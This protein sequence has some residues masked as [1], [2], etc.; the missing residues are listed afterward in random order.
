MTAAE[1]AAKAEEQHERLSFS[2]DE[3]MRG[4]EIVIVAQALRAIAAEL[5]AARLERQLGVRNL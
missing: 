2:V 1:A 3:I 5:R 4:E